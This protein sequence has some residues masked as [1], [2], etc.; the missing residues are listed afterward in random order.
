MNAAATWVNA[1]H[2][3]CKR[4]AAG[5]RAFTWFNAATVSWSSCNSEGA[6]VAMAWMKTTVKGVKD[7]YNKIL[8]KKNS[9]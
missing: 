2:T 1:A 7:G 8:G 6:D 9:Y 3:S 4:R 5:E